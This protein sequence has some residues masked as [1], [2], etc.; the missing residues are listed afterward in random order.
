MPISLVENSSI[1][2]SSPSKSTIS[3][4]IHMRINI[5]IWN[6]K[7]LMFLDLAVS[8]TN[9]PRAITSKTSVRLPKDEENST[10]SSVIFQSP[11]P[12]S[13]SYPKHQDRLLQTQSVRLWMQAQTHR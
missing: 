2:P 5:D 10:R 1:T 8:H 6:W 3:P 11:P 13:S 4:V 7:L 9:I 12:F